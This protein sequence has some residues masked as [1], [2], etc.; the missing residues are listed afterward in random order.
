MLDEGRISHRIARAH[1]P[2]ARTGEAP[3]QIIA[4]RGWLQISDPAALAPLVAQALAAAGEQTA[5]LRAGEERLLDYFVGQVMRLTAG[6]ADPQVAAQL[7]R[8]AVGLQPGGV[9]Q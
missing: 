2:T 7:L 8:A 5:R 4:A 6:R 9:A 3:E 1:L